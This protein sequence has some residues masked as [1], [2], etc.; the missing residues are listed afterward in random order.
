MGMTVPTKKI[1]IQM[2]SMTIVEMIKAT[3]RTVIIGKI[4]VI[5]I[6]IL[7]ITDIIKIIEISREQAIETGETTMEAEAITKTNDTTITDIITR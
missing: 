3:K 5:G 4:A 1:K 7:G 6:G 2:T